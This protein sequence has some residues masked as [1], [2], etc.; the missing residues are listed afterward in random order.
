MWDRIPILSLPTE[1][2]S[3][4]TATRL[5]S[6]PTPNAEPARCPGFPDCPARPL[7]RAAVPRVRGPVALVVSRGGPAVGNTAGEL[8]LRVG[9]LAAVARLGRLPGPAG[10]GG[11]D[12]CPAPRRLLRPVR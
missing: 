11:P 6:C 10:L 4:P 5:E 8:G 7:P 12:R 9:G 3:C 1:L 2:E